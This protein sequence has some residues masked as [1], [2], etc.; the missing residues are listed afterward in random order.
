MEDKECWSGMDRNKLEGGLGPPVKSNLPF[1]KFQVREFRL[2]LFA[3]KLNF[4]VSFNGQ[5]PTVKYAGA[6]VN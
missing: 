6:W 5:G 2:D 4:L 1:L 3:S